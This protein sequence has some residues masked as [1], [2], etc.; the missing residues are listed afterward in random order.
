M[1]FTTI[2][3]VGSKWYIFIIIRHIHCWTKASSPLAMNYDTVP[4]SDKLFLQIIISA[5]S[6]WSPFSCL[7]AFVFCAICSLLPIYP[8]HIY[9]CFFV[10][11]HVKFISSLIHIHLQLPLRPHCSFLS[12]LPLMMRSIPIILYSYQAHN[13]FTLAIFFSSYV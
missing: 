10:L 7:P 5:P 12:V 4:T 13:M 3:R 1:K 6:G 2:G 9:F 11:F 8:A